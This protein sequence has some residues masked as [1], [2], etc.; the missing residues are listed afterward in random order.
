MVAHAEREIEGRLLK[1]DRLT[2]VETEDIILTEAI[3]CKRIPEKVVEASRSPHPPPIGRN[4]FRAAYHSSH[5]LF[6]S[7]RNKIKVIPC[8]QHLL[9][10]VKARVQK[11]RSA[12]KRIEAS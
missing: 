3:D 2:E 9:K 1:T 11:A 12:Q 5:L 8:T 4:F 6:I 7:R 10:I